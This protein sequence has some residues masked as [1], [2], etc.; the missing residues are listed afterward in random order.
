MGHQSRICPWWQAYTFDNPLRR[1]FHKPGKMLSPYVE[2]GMRVLDIGCGMGYFSIAMAKM[3]GPGGAVLAVD[4]QQKMLDVTMK[5]AA[6]AGVQE[7]INPLLMDVLSLGDIGKVD[8]ALAFW[9]VHE[10]P[11]QKRFF[12]LMQAA[13][14]PESRLLI[15][16]PLFHVRRTAFERT[17]K[18]AHD[19]GFV[20]EEAPRI[21]FSRT[22]CLRVG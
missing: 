5:R 4:V 20:P 16:E 1:L 7:R 10:V 22:T 12:G 2:P 9:V 15:A 8:F 11:D 17:L 13:L 6:R 19:T 18:I 14:L 21:A 3:V